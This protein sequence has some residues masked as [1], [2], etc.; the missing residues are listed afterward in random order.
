MG[1]APDFWRGHLRA[2]A[3]LQVAES[4]ARADRVM[5]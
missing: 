2:L 3:V 5:I 1:W 4:R